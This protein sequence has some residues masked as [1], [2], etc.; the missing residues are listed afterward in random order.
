MDLDHIP[1]RDPVRSRELFQDHV[2]SGP[3]VDGI[4]WH[5]IARRL[6]GVILGFMQRPGPPRRV[7][8]PFHPK[9]PRSAQRS[10]LAERRQ[11]S[12]HHRDRHRPAF[13]A[14]QHRQLVLAPARKLLPQTANLFGLFDRP[15]GS[16]A[17]MRPVGTVLQ[18][19]QLLRIVVPLPAI[20]G[21]TAD[22]EITA[23][24]GCIAAVR[25][26]MIEPLQPLARLSAQFR[27]APLQVTG[28]GRSTR[29]DLPS[30][31]LP[32]VSTIILNE[33]RGFAPDAAGGNVVGRAECV[34]RISAAARIPGAGAA[35][36]ADPAGVAECD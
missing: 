18:H 22:P 20:K 29:D 35:A 25:S 30:D 13:P 31:T 3:Q 32:R 2:G 33:N 14:Q 6:H 17:V 12:A 7:S 5:Q 10:A 15:G 27:A 16:E 23:S 28:A 11:D 4:E 21:F 34:Y 19:A 9:D 26:V 24:Q 8:S 36:S 1:A